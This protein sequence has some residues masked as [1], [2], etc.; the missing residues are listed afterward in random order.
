MRQRHLETTE[1]CS[2]MVADFTA[3]N[4]Q[5]SKG[6]ISEIEARRRKTAT[7]YKKDQIWPPAWERC[8]LSQCH[9]PHPPLKMQFKRK[10][11][12]S[13]KGWRKQSW[14]TV[15]GNPDACRSSG[16]PPSFSAHYS[17]ETFQ[18]AQV[19]T[20]GSGFPILGS[21][22]TLSLQQTFCN[23]RACQERQEPLAEERS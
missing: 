7:S 9:L 12:R 14:W 2:E 16:H 13:L 5:Q 20:G 6:L 8:F 22:A 15:M 11:G 19:M 18:S 4:E 3:D 1:R 23:Q 21:A 17:S 10:E